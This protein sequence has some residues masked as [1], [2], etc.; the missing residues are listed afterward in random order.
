LRRIPTRRK[1][2]KSPENEHSVDVRGR[3]LYLI[4]RRMYLFMPIFVIG[5]PSTH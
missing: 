2:R 1:D 5:D 4:R 3:E